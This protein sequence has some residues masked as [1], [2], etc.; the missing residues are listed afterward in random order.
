MLA[1]FEHLSDT[2]FVNA[3][4]DVGERELD[5]A[6]QI[7]FDLDTFFA[8]LG[9][10]KSSLESAVNEEG[11]SVAVAG[12]SPSHSP[13]L[14]ITIDSGDLDIKATLFEPLEKL[15]DCAKAPRTSSK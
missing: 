12:Y 13:Q 6:S 8:T 11:A 10:A 1:Q 4:V 9:L 14:D 5:F 2:Y 15:L 3:D 7:D